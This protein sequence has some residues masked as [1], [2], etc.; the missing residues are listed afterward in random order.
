M[1]WKSRSKKRTCALRD[2]QKHR[3]ETQILTPVPESLSRMHPHQDLPAAVRT[4]PPVTAMQ[5]SKEHVDAAALSPVEAA[6]A[7]LTQHLLHLA[8]S[9]S[10]GHSAHCSDP[11]CSPTSLTTSQ[12]P[13]PLLPLERRSPPSL[14]LPLSQ[15]H[16][17]DPATVPK[18]SWNMEDSPDQLLC[19][20]QLSYFK[21]LGIPFGQNW[22]QFFWG[23]PSL[24]SESLIAAA[25][26]AHGPPVPNL[27]TSFFNKI[28]NVCAVHMQDK[29]SLLRSQAQGS[30]CLG[31]RSQPRFQPQPLG[32]AQTR[33]HP[34][35]SS[36]IL[37]PLCLPCNRDYGAAASTSHSNPRSLT[38]NEIQASEKLLCKKQLEWAWSV[39][40]PVQRSQEGDSHSMY[41]RTGLLQDK[42]AT[43]TLP[44]SFPISPE[45][46][47]TLD[48]HIQKWITEHQ[49]DLLYKIQ[50][51]AEVTRALRDMARSC[52]A[53]DKLRPSPSSVS[54]AE[55]SKDKPWPSPS[56]VSTAEGS[57][58][59]PRPSP[60]SVS[61]AEGSQDKPQPS[62]SSLSIAESSKNKPQSSPSSL[63]VAEG[64]SDVQVR[65]Q[66]RQDLDRILGHILA[67][68]PK[69]VS[70]ELGSSPR[71]VQKVILQKP[72]RN[73]TR[74]TERESRNDLPESMDKKYIKDMLKTHL[75]VKT[76]QMHMGMIPLRVCQSLLNGNGAFSASD[77]HVETRKP[78]SSR[79]QETCVNPIQKFSFS[80]PSTLQNLE[81][82]ITRFRF[83]R[84]SSFGGM[85]WADL[86]IEDAKFLGK[87]PEA[88]PEEIAI[89][90]SVPTLNDL[91]VSSL[92]CKETEQALLR[93]PG[94]QA[95]IMNKSEHTKVKS[96]NNPQ[97]YDSD[98]YLPDSLASAMPPCHRHSTPLGQNLASQMVAGLKT[99]RGRGMG[100]QKPGIPQHQHA[101][102]SQSK[103][104]AP[105]YKQEVS[106]RTNPGKHKDRLGDLRT[107]AP[108]WD[109]RTEDTL[110]KKNQLLTQK[111]P[112]PSEGYIQGSVKKFLQWISSEKKVKRQEEPQKKGTS[113]IVQ[114]QRPTQT[115]PRM[116]HSTDEAQLIMTAVGQ[117]LEAKLMLQQEFCAQ[118]ANQNKE[119]EGQDP[120]SQGSCFS[121]Q[122]RMPGHTATPISH[123]CPM[124]ERYPRDQESL[125]TRQ[126]SSG[127]QSQRLPHPS[128]PTKLSL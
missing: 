87:P 69:D 18:P 31:P 15:P 6:P 85:S 22:S 98:V 7:P 12:P 67:K 103:M 83:V 108:T 117:M 13:E 128:V 97:V 119:K 72:E 34:Q 112:V 71:M 33:K 125:K 59:K 110:E 76:G 14:A 38:P 53:K 17:P 54:T 51:D 100:H 49:R 8:S 58:D 57:K 39:P 92:L 93:E 50:E 91:F 10:P 23:L 32:H 105:V 68:A 45:L 96:L 19:T 94:L 84:S 4:S 101:Q 118:K 95:D 28:S 77:T 81:M 124:R 29:M 47:E 60:S 2:F 37:S 122:R 127:Q 64:S 86:T 55:G 116:N 44:E 24:H 106:W 46:R 36:P 9:L 80:K 109:R 121:D 61:K 82:H 30:P 99:D 126:C 3:K 88:F 20:D 66:L 16:P 1:R 104:F 56:S 102:K 25:R 48:Q 41:P 74:P 73:L 52:Q 40:S 114:S 75:G 43:A 120:L 21:I 113:S 90:E 111:K 11:Q 70:R 5:P 27:P 26:I 78:P 65:F 35:S 89:R 107:L 62:P 42:S 79:A 115:R 123:S 63:S